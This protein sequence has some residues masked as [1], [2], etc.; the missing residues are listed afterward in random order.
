MKL[1]PGATATVEVEPT[2][3]WPEP[4]V[5][6]DLKQ[7]LSAAPQIIQRSVAGHH[8]DG[9]VGMG[10]L[11]QRDQQPRYPQA[12]G[13]GEHLEAEEG[14]APPVLLQPLGVHQS[15]AVEEAAGS[16]TPSSCRGPQAA[17][18]R[19][20]GRGDVPAAGHAP[21]LAARPTGAR[22]SGLLAPSSAVPGNPGG[23]RMS[24]VV[25]RRRRLALLGMVIGST[26]VAPTF[27]DRARVRHALGR[28]G[29][30][31]SRSVRGDGT[32]VPRAEHSCRLV[33]GR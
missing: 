21:P 15:G 9:A 27:V 25:S 5:P 13:R 23:N 22:T 19:R 18:S 14:Q 6:P 26:H 28:L 32:G 3:D 8:A 7:A 30:R 16:S 31:G 29:W 12:A 11:G 2:K 17:R 20:A 4:R 1:R 10:S 24:F 33:R